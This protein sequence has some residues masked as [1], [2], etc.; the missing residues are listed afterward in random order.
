MR[1]AASASFCFLKGKLRSA[2]TDFMFKHEARG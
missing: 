2:M 1:W